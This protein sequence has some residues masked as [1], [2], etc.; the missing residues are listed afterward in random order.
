MPK[1]ISSEALIAD[2]KQVANTLGRCPT[3]REHSEL[4]KFNYMTAIRRFGSWQAVNSIAGLAPDSIP[5]GRYQSPASD[6]TWQQVKS[7]LEEG[8]SSAE[9]AERFKDEGI[10]AAAIYTRNYKSWH[11]NC[12]PKGRRLQANRGFTDSQEQEMVRLYTDE[13]KSTPEIAAI[14]SCHPSTV[15][16]ALRWNGTKARRDYNKGKLAG[17]KHPQWKGGKTKTI[18][19]IR[20]TPEYKAWRKAVFER[21]NYACQ[22]CGTKGTIQADHILPQC[23]Y[24][25]LRF[26]LTNGRTLCESCH[27]QTPTYGTKAKFYR[28]DE[29]SEELRKLINLSNQRR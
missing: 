12:R 7:L 10:T 5:K 18:K 6:S 11:I 26:E 2:V 16:R 28:P 23:H 20:L 21:D 17:E 19:Y 24:P 29:N 1:R 9:I 4:G 15:Q 3:L 27:R 25:E 8:I 14:F 22:N 13:N